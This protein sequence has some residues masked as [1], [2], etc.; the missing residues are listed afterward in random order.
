MK[1][2]LFWKSSGMRYIHCTHHI[3]F[4]N[5]LILLPKNNLVNT[6]EPSHCPP[7]LFYGHQHLPLGSCIHPIYIDC[8]YNVKHN[9]SFKLYIW[10]WF[11]IKMSHP[12]FHIFL[13]SPPIPSNYR[14]P[15]I[16]ISTLHCEP[17]K[18]ICL[19]DL[20]PLT[21]RPLTWLLPSTYFFHLHQ[22]S[23]FI[24]WQFPLLEVQ[25]YEF[26]QNSCFS[27]CYI[28]LVFIF[29]L[30]KSFFNTFI[31]LTS[32]KLGEVLKLLFFHE[33]FIL[34]LRPSTFNP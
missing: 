18:P 23:I 25:T 9:P 28:S 21:M 19:V 13:P 31:C 24:N 15:N 22:S 7:K 11:A 10:I 34:P 17:M 27:N 14:S 3:Q 6:S 1:F 33:S 32:L 4:N 29:Y 20:L 16:I 5:L 2:Q 12:N 8:L 26:C 30:F